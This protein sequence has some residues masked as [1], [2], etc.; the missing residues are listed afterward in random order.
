M[1]GNVEP[2]EVFLGEVNS[3]SGAVRADVT[4]D[5]GQLKGKAE[6]DR[7]L[8]RF[9]SERSEDSQA[10][11]T[12]RGRDAIAI[13]RQVFEGWVAMDREVHLHP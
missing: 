6:I 5:I 3:S 7:V 8:F 9:R 10:D 12:N 1:L 11:E 13:D 2:L 4:Q